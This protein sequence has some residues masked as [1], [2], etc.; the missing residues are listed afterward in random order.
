M[1]LELHQIQGRDP[2]L[3]GA[4][5]IAYILQKEDH[6][7]VKLGG[8]VRNTE[9]VQ[10]IV[11]ESYETVKAMIRLKSRLVTKGMSFFP[12]TTWG[13]ARGTDVEGR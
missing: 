9:P 7:I 4:S 2:V 11:E 12:D 1:F 10:F 13:E 8:A 6:T 3:I 5:H